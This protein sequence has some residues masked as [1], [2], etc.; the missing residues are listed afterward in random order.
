MQSGGTYWP[1]FPEGGLSF[2]N[3]NSPNVESLISGDCSA[4]LL[5]NDTSLL[6]DPSGTWHDPDFLSH[7]VLVFSSYQLSCDVSRAI[8][9][10]LSLPIDVILPLSSQYQQ[11][12]SHI[13]ID[14][15]TS[16]HWL[17]TRI[18]FMCISHLNIQLRSD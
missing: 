15:K 2:N 6:P 1:H 14:T 9:G 13:Q 8:R 17:Q 3:E 16:C 10:H 12:I 18:S 7:L 4:K 11:F 5:S